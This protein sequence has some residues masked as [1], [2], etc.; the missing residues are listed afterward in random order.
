MRPTLVV[1]SSNWATVT[2]AIPS[3]CTAAG[4]VAPV[5]SAPARS[6]TSRA[7]CASL[8][9]LNS[10][11]CV[12]WITSR[13][14][15][16]SMPVTRF[17]PA[18]AF[19]GS[20]AQRT[21]AAAVQMTCS[22]ILFS[23]PTLAAP[24]GRRRLRRRH[25]F[26]ALSQGLQVRLLVFRLRHL[27]GDVLRIDPAGVPVGD[28]LGDDDLVALDRRHLSPVLAHEVAHPDRPPAHLGILEHRHRRRRS[29]DRQGEP[30]LIERPLLQ[31]RRLAALR[32]HAVVR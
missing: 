32:A 27:D 9:A 22:F 2:P 16:T 28:G 25:H 5:T 17:A 29:G 11:F 15:S 6:T 4:A 21:S 3:L 7:G 26:F 10:G 20:A 19:A 14:P 31:R 18:P 1:P 23:W 13:G 8:N 12:P 30:E 24:R